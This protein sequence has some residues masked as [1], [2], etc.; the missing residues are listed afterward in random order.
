MGRFSFLLF[1]KIFLLKFS[2]VT[3]VASKYDKVYNP[4]F[5][6]NFLKW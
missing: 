6:Q 3:F 4:Y 1:F 5:C 2:F